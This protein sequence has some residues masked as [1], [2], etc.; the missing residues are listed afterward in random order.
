MAILKKYKFDIIILLIFAVVILAPILYQG[1]IY[2]SLGDDSAAHM[3]TIDKIA[4]GDLAPDTMYLGTIIAGIPIRLFSKL[5]GISTNSLFLWFSFLSLAAVA[6]TIYFVTRSFVGKQAALL[7]TIL[8]IFCTQSILALFLFG[9]IFNIINMYIILMLG[10]YFLVKFLNERKPWQAVASGGL[11][12]IF[13]IFHTTALYLPY[14]ALPLIGL[15]SLYYLIQKKRRDMLEVSFFGGIAVAASV[16]LSKIFL[17]G[18]SLAGV[19]SSPSTI[20]YMADPPAFPGT[21]TG[22]LPAAAES[23]A[24]SVVR[25]IEFSPTFGE[26]IIEYLS[27]A[28]LAIL[29]ASVIGLIIYRKKV[30]WSSETKLFIGIL[31]CFG[32]ATLIGSLSGLVPA[33]VRLMLDS[34]TLFAIVAGCLA[35]VLLVTIKSRIFTC[36]ILAVIVI[37]IVPTMTTWATAH[38]SAM[39]PIDTQTVEYIEELDVATYSC[40]TQVAPW[41]YDRFLRKQYLPDGKGEI[42]IYRSQPM[43]TSTTEGNAYFQYTREN[44]LEDFSSLEL[45]KVFQD[46]GISIYLFRGGG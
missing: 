41:I 31:S 24:E 8:A 26:Y 42:V 2:P 43:T 5:T 22:Q 32:A 27:P 16:L 17:P 46:T 36:T 30:K 20:A 23:A 7:A 33:P 4:A 12:S 37:G 35:G 14:V 18:F 25:V 28:T 44:T 34:S 9:V 38:N 29:I 10:I 45:I 3:R 6:V 15:A 39:K 19:T 40:S 1:Y 21:A 11:A 13:S